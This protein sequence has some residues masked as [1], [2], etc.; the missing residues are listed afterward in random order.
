[1]QD[2]SPSAV[3]AKILSLIAA[4]PGVEAARVTPQAT[5]ADL[6]VASLDAIEVIFDIEEIF[7]VTLSDRDADLK[8]GTVSGLIE[9]V[10][11][12]VDAKAKS[13]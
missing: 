1:M 10:Q 7:D 9:A 6:G 13:S 4:R 12:A 2:T 11:R 3:Q 5:L 8:S